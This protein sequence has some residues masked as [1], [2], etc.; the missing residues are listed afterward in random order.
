MC[1]GGDAKVRLRLGVGEFAWVKVKVKVRAKVRVRVN[2]GPFSRPPSLWLCIRRAHA[3]PNTK[4][5]EFSLLRLLFRC[6]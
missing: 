4:P 6:C 2:S 3:E 5:L 1:G